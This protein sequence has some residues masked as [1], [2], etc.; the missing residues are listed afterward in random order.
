VVSAL[1]DAAPEPKSERVAENYVVLKA[2]VP[3]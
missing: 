2:C 1:L 3:T